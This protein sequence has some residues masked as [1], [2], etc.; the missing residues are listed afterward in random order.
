MDRKRKTDDEDDIIT[1][2]QSKKQNTNQDGWNEK[3]ERIIISIGENAAGYKWMHEKSANMYKYINQVLS[4]VLI[5]FSAGLTAETV[6]PTVSSDPA[7]DIVKRVLTYFVTAISVV[8]SFLKYE[9]LS[10][11][12]N[13]AAGNF[14]ELYHDIQQQMC[15]YRRERKPAVS[16]MAE[17]LTKYDTLV[18]QTPI[19]SKLIISQFKKTFQNASISMPEIADE[20]HKIEIVTEPSEENHQNKRK[21]KFKT[22][23]IEMQQLNTQANP[24]CNLSEIHEI[25]QNEQQMRFLNQKDNYEYERFMKHNE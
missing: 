17:I 25:T 22:K 15:M 20:I 3:N 14:S 6:F 13:N 12:H 23:S 7:V 24:I 2:L 4:I 5:V 8:Q 11:Q 19:I 1:P 16:Y 21:F 9:Q 10:E 18:I